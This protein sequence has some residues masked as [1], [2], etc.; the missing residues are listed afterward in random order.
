MPETPEVKTNTFTALKSLFSSRKF[1]LT[2]VGS[3]LVITLQ[4]LNV[5]HEILIL[6]AGLFGVNIYGIAKEGRYTPANK[7]EPKK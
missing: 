7:E 5:S 6:I 2:I 1:L 3:V 4:Q